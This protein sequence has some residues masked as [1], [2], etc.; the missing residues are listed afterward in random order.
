MSLN[1]LVNAIIKLKELATNVVVEVR[2]I[3]IFHRY[4]SNVFF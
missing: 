1:V 4:L 3:E 2:W